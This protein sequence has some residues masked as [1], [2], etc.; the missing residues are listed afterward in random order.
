MYLD[1]IYWI[2]DDSSLR[3]LEE[4]CGERMK[5][6]GRMFRDDEHEFERLTVGAT[7][8]VML[9]RSHITQ[10]KITLPEFPNNNMRL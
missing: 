1:P 7:P 5:E 10:K 3:L 9:K 6:K 4:E 2:M 8:S